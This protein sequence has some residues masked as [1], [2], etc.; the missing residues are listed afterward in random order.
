MSAKAT[1]RSKIV[2]G[3]RVTLEGKRVFVWPRP[4]DEI[5]RSAALA[6]YKGTKY[7]KHLVKR[8]H[9][10]KATALQDFEDTCNAVLLGV[11]PPSVDY[12]ETYYSPGGDPNGR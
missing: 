11:L 10:D 12:R 8:H 2:L 5:Y 9:I 6:L 4:D 7:P 1:F 3:R